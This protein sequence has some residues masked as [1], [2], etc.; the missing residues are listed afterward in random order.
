MRTSLNLI[1]LLLLSIAP[2]TGQVTTGFQLENQNDPDRGGL[3]GNGITDLQYH[4]GNTYIGTGFGL[5][6]SPDDGSTWQNYT[7]ADYG[8]KGGVSAMTVGPDG[9]LW[10]ATAYDSTVQDDQ[11]LQVGG[12]LRFLEPG[13]TTWGFI[14]QPVDAVTDTMGGMQPTTTRVQNVTFDI[15]VTD[16]QIWIATFGGGLRVSEDMGQTWRVVTTDGQPFDVLNNSYGLNHRGF[17]VIDDT[18]GTIWVGTVQGVSRS[19]DAGNTW[20]RFTYTN[21]TS[22]ISGNWVI[23]LFHNPWNN[24]IWATTLRSTEQDEFNG[25][26]RTLNQGQSW[27]QFLVP[28]LSDGTFPRAVAFYDSATYVATEKGVFKSIDDG[29]NWFL[30]PPIRDVVSGEGLFTSTFYSV[31]TSPAPGAEHRLWIGSLDGLASTENSGFDWTVYRSF[32][33]TRSERSDPAVYAYPNPYSPTQTDRP[34]RFQFDVEGAGT[35]TVE[36]YNYAM[37]KVVTLT[38]VIESVAMGGQD[39]SVPWD[40]MDS[41]G[42]MV[43]NGVYF[44]RTN[45][46]GQVNWGK[47]VIIN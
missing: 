7:P 36:V 23:G 19:T 16:T 2:L 17:S 12:G 44:F 39:R 34:C 37:E 3:I 29:Q 45:I 42:R 20:E 15:A 8:F 33:S 41:N 10:I 46:G 21:Q 28:E 22:P 6:L 31:T 24:S 40:G 35:A 26:S 14:S 43:D 4:N 38:S 25:I 18:S 9:T 5:S 11:S 47:I 1:L 32:V 30:I 27:D 13:S